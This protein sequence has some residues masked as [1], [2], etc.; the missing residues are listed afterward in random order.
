MKLR[1]PG[2]RE[3]TVHDGILSHYLWGPKLE[4][5]LVPDRHIQ[6]LWLIPIYEAERAYRK[7]HGTDALEQRFEA[8]SFD[9]LDPFRPS[10]VP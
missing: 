3:P 4:H 2:R 10:V 9:Y 7:V 8:T 6:V 5:C 1:L